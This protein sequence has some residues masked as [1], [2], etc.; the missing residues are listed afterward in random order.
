MEKT[1]EEDVRLLWIW[2]WCSAGIASK[3]FAAI[4][5]GKCLSC[6]ACSYSGYHLGTCRECR[7]ATSIPQCS[8]RPL[9]V[10]FCPVDMQR[11][12]LECLAFGR[13]RED[14]A[15]IFRP[16]PTAYHWRIRLCIPSR[17]PLRSSSWSCQGRIF[18]TRTI[19]RSAG[20]SHARNSYTILVHGRSIFQV[21]TAL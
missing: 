4:P 12:R 2:Y 17:T 6:R 16:S 5:A 11:R 21:D 8:T 20:R 3:L 13:F 10:L 9:W 18:C 19:L 7:L 1:R 14:T 15:R